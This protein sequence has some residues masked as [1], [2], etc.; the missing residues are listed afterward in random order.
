MKNARTRAVRFIGDGE[1][2]KLQILRKKNEPLQDLRR[3][4]GKRK[5]MTMCETRPID[6]IVCDGSK[7][8][9]H[10]KA[11]EQMWKIVQEILEKDKKLMEM[12]ADA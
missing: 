8:N 9:I 12:L 7:D 6:A 4:L 3:V 10:K 5:E 1:I 11:L 2:D